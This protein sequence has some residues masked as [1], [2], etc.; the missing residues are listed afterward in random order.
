MRTQFFTHN[1]VTYE[2][3]VTSDGTSNFVRV[4]R[5]GEH[6]QGLHYEVSIE[7]ADDANVAG[8]DVVKDLIDTAIRAITEI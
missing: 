4:F 8:L 3:R 5:D 2:I 7:T 1:D 6:V